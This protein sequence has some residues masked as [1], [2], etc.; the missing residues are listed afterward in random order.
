LT[1]IK[2][3][4]RYSKRRRLGKLGN[5]EDKVKKE[6]AILKKARHPNVVSLLEVIDDPAKKKV[7]IVLEYVE[8]GE[9]NWRKKGNRDIVLLERH[10]IEQVMLGSGEGA[11]EEI[12]R[13]HQQAERRRRWREQR[14]RHEHHERHDSHSSA[15]YWSLE[16][17]GES[18]EDE[19][20]LIRTATA[21][22]YPDR[23]HSASPSALRTQAP[24]P[25]PAPAPASYEDYPSIDSETEGAGAGAGAGEAHQHS[26]SS[27]AVA[28]DGHGSSALDGH[29]SS[30]LDGHGSS[31]LDGHGSSALDGHGSSVSEHR[32]RAP[33][34]SDS[35]VSNLSS[36]LE[37]D[38]FDEDFS[39]VPCF[40]I[41]QARSTF[42]D[43]VL[44]LE[45][46]H[47]QGII[48]RDIKPA[49]LLWTSQHR[50][51]ISDF[52]V[53]YLGRPVRD[54]EAGEEL[55]ESESQTLD[56]ALELA[57]TVGTPAFFAPELCNTDF[58]AKRPPITGQ[59]DVWSLGVTLYCLI[60][61]RLP[62]LAEDEYKLFK[63][64]AEDELYIP[65]KRLKP[66]DPKPSSRSS[67]HKRISPPAGPLR[68]DNE[69][70]YEDIDAELRDLLNRLLL[71]DPAKRITL[72]E[73]K[74]HPWVLRGIPDHIA[75]LEETDPSRQSGGRKIEVSHEDVEK[76]VVSVGV[77]ERVRSGMRKIGN[78]LMGGGRKEAHRRRAQSSAASTDGDLSN[79]SASST[80]I[81]GRE[82][83]RGSLR[84]DEA[85]ASAPAPKSS[86]PDG[87]HPLAQSVT[88]SPAG[89]VDDDPFRTVTTV[90]AN[91]TPQC[92]S[93]T[94]S[95]APSH[96]Y[97]SRPN[98]LERVISA[99][100]S[101]KTIIK[102]VRPDTPPLSSYLPSTSQIVEST[103][104]PA[105]TLS[106]IFG[107]AGRRMVGRMR[108]RD[109][110]KDNSSS[111]SSRAKSVDRVALAGHD[112]HAE[113][114]VAFC[115]AFASGH[116]DAPS[117]LREVNT[118]TSPGF[119]RPRPVS[120]IG[121]QTPPPPEAS[122]S[123]PVSV[124][125]ASLSRPTTAPAPDLNWSHFPMGTQGR[126]S[127]PESFARA[128][129]ELF[130]RRRFELEQQRER[131]VEEERAA[132]SSA[133]SDTLPECPPSPD[134]EAH[135]K[136][137]DDAAA[138]SRGPPSPNLF[139]ALASPASSHNAPI[140]SSSSEDQFNTSYTT[141]HPS[142][143][144]M[145]SA[146]S[147]LSTC[148]G[149]D[150]TPTP[151]LIARGA[152]AA[153]PLLLRTDDTGKTVTSRQRPASADEDDAGYSGDHQPTDDDD[154]DS[155]ED[156]FL[157]M[158]GRRR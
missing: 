40:T 120:V 27:S 81:T 157:Q 137:M 95:D 67:S 16:Y 8:L 14:G 4:D 138:A 12:A 144:S 132:L 109:F 148:G 33:S 47:Y 26:N 101:T 56:E 84:G 24:A 21:D 28:L 52:G 86:R 7:Y 11:S 2:I 146:G 150:A 123:R 46:L 51:K 72:K 104:S 79:R 50:V 88:A 13:L 141:S 80:S 151:E 73:V 90:S 25:A 103:T 113:P 77:L 23:L 135:F 36:E 29:G 140:T 153:V 136:K 76:A 60:F 6:V 34:M 126:V 106:N 92:A 65:T 54:D 15:N 41:E 156:D 82:G 99:S 19:D 97:P 124:C 134:N 105:S 64:I 147:S 114:S 20:R 9:I 93:P 49:N 142:L 112:P 89:S 154:D 31:A 125:L 130:R 119:S 68:D 22:N 133:R 78:T 17:G 102:T 30:A 63:A 61:A 131:S 71:K 85:V 5:P 98:N 62:F 43:T 94:A 58:T 118:P 127:T 139:S 108:S 39:Y 83:R 121:G 129:D 38:S 70:V 110:R 143:P 155:D 55:S 42:R 37:M 48:H 115:N 3:V 100:G 35:Y 74:R 107:G 59:I 122:E 45:Y 10:R 128:Q 32:G 57:K 96:T 149:A 145:V 117:A 53:S 111:S 152:Q 44:G 87:E 69:L 91:A 1:A 158:G 116:V 75:W 66:V 18:E